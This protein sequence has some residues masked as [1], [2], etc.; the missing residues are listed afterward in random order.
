MST[1]PWFRLYHRMID[2]TKIKLLAFED[3]W[4][5][6]ALCCLTANGTLA[7]ADEDLKHRM[8]AVALGVQLRELDEIR[9]RLVAVNLIGPDMV[10]L[11]W[12]ELQFESDNSTERVRKFR[13]KQRR[14]KEK[15]FR[16]VAVT[17]QETEPDSD[18]DPETDQNTPPEGGDALSN[19]DDEPLTVED[20]FEGWNTFAAKYGLPVAE[21]LTAERRRAA[22]QRLKQYPELS[23]WQKALRHIR[24][25]PFLRGENDRGWQAN[26]DF[27]LQAKSFTKLVEGAYAKADT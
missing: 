21:K 12:D 2:D 6:V 20:I 3:R 26:F 9:R 18:P 27:F 16:N 23:S 24:E 22:R 25:T 11:A 4:H 7:E 10:P 1:M 8:V 14:N 5:F 15:R 17:G 19:S 13:E